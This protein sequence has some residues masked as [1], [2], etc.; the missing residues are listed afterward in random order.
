MSEKMSLQPALRQEK[1]GIY[2]GETGKY[3]NRRVQACE[4]EWNAEKDKGFGP[5][6]FDNL[7]LGRLQAALGRGQKEV[8]IFDFGCG[9]G[10]LLL[11]F[12]QGSD[13]NSQAL[14]FLQSH[15]E[16]KLRYVG[17]T[18]S[19]GLRHLPSE[20][21]L[22]TRL[23]LSLPDA[24]PANI[25]AYRVIYAVTAVQTLEK[26]L[27]A[28]HLDNVDLGVATQSLNYLS[29]LVFQP[30]LDSLFKRMAMPGSQFVA[31]PYDTRLP[32]FRSIM[33]GVELD[34][35]AR[36]QGLSNRLRSDR[37]KVYGEGVNFSEIAAHL[38]QALQLYVR[39][40][41]VEEQE[42]RAKIHECLPRWLRL[43]NLLRKQ[44]PQFHQLLVLD[45]KKKRMV[46][47]SLISRLTFSENELYR[48]KQSKVSAQKHAIL[49][50]IQQQYPGLRYGD[51]VIEFVR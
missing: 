26:F 37:L 6:S 29:S 41:M 32:G 10:G 17:L 18:D 33:A 42:M 13:G 45:N 48:R 14:Q 19:S 49:A 28:E 9:E 12:L 39:L 22:H 3:L 11:D 34:A 38:E 44:Q 2:K 30:T 8:L 46:F 24:A 47:S 15:P 5:Y 21:K 25:E 16:L 50:Q 7:V 4:A 36:D 43:R 27:A 23:P 20:A 40:G 1:V 35:R 31:A 51:K